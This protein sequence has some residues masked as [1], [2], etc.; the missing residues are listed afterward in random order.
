MALFFQ[1]L[2]S[3]YILIIRV[4]EA[5][6]NTIIIYQ[7]KFLTIISTETII[8]FQLRTKQY[9]YYYLLLSYYNCFTPY[10]RL[11]LWDSQMINNNQYLLW[12]TDRLRKEET[13]LR[14]RS[15]F[16]V[17]FENVNSSALQAMNINMINVQ[18]WILLTD[19]EWWIYFIIKYKFNVFSS[20][21]NYIRSSS[22]TF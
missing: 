11:Q 18:K 3:H 20:L 9:F 10:I 15:S 4:T 5:Y 6:N 1:Y 21:Y 12:T 17:I 7:L 14:Q 22:F 13:R 2:E 16:V 8:K 19:Y